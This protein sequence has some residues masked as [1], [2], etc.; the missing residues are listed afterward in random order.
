[1]TSTGPRPASGT[2]LRRAR[3]LFTLVAI[4]VPVVIVAVAAVVLSGWLPAFTEPVAVHWGTGG[5]DGFGPASLY[6]WL[7]L[8]VGLGVPL[9]LVVTT[10]VAVRD[11]WGGA[12]RLMGAL[13]AG[14]SAFAAVTSLGSLWIQRDLAPGAEVPGVGGVTAAALAALLVVGGAAWSVQP[15]YRTPAGRPLA[16]RQDVSVGAAERVVWLATTTMP[17]GALILLGLVLAGMI[18]LAATM[19]SLGVAGWWVVAVGALV[20]AVALAATASYRV[21]ITPEGFSARSLLGRPRVD[22]PVHEIVDVRAIDVSPF[23]DF[24]GWGWRISTDGRTGIVT[25]RGPAIEVSRRERA[26]FLVTIDGA[27]EGAA[28]LRTYVDRHT[29]GP[30]AATGEGDR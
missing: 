24:G 28:L 9:L 3:L 30:A 4:V 14:M 29:G 1:M 17:R 11:Q 23:G 21:S 16:P 6:L 18:V 25:R 15:R 8:G 7:L 5:A 26:S 12:A 19:L 27:E 13:A 10:L 2:P 20:V 22:I